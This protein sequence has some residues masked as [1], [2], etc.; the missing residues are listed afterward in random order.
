MLTATVCTSGT[1]TKQKLQSS[2]K[3][4]NDAERGEYV[5]F[6]LFMLAVLFCYRQTGIVQLEAKTNV[7]FECEFVCHIAYSSEIFWW[8]LTTECVLGRCPSIS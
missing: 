8:I 3:T 4:N 2:N 5:L 1:V 6:K 7:A